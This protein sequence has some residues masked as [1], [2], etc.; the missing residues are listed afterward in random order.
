MRRFAFPLLALSLWPLQSQA[1]SQGRVDDNP[2]YRKG[3]AALADHLPDL[4]IGPLKKALEEF[5]GNTAATLAIRLRLAEAHIRAGRIET[6]RDGAEGQGSAALGYLSSLVENKNEEAIFWAAQAHILRAELTEAV[7][8]LARLDNAE[9]PGMRGRSALSRA[10]LLAL[11]GNPGSAG[12]LLDKLT[13]S[14]EAPLS[15]DARILHATILL[16]RDELVQAATLLSAGPDPLDRNRKL[17]LRFLRAKLLARTDKPEAIKVFQSIVEETDETPRLLRHS[18]EV[19]LA[20]CLQATGQSEQAIETLINLIDKEPR[21]SLL[22]AAFHRL[23]SWAVTESQKNRIEQQFSTWANLNNRDAPSEPARGE[24]ILSPDTAQRSGYAIYYYAISLGRQNSAASNEKARTLLNWLIENLPRHP[25]N[26]PATLEVAKLQIAAQQKQEAIA[27]L[28]GLKTSTSSNR[29]R[30]ET[31]RLLGRLEFEQKDFQAA[32]AAFLPIRQ[33]LTNPWEDISVINAGVSLL[34][35]GDNSEFAAL[36]RSIEDSKTQATL[37]L[38]RALYQSSQELNDARPDLDRFL[39]NYPEDPRIPEARLAM[40]E[41]HLRLEPS[42]EASHRQVL[43]ELRSLQNTSL[44][45][46]LDLRRLLIHLRL[47]GLTDEWEP[48]IA[49]SKLFLNA[50]K[51]ER[52]SSMVRLKVS[53]AYFKNGNLSEAQARFQEIVSSSDDEVIRE[54]ATYYAARA[55]LKLNTGSS[56]EEAVTLL[57]RVIDNEGPLA[58]EARL[59]LADSQIEEAPEKSIVLLRPLLSADSPA[60][61]DALMLTA[62]AHRE[63]GAPSDLRSALGIYDAVLARPELAYPLSNRLFWLKGQVFEELGQSQPAL[64]AYY[65]VVRRE[66]LPEAEHP[67]EWYYFSRCAF[68]AVEILEQGALPRW[69]AA[70]EILRKVENSESPWRKEAGRRRAEIQLEHQLFDS[71]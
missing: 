34:R 65:H 47:A 31:G 13:T 16:D 30:E 68:D 54:T 19:F 41:E 23:T 70:V 66:N 18:A 38:E 32:A 20:E 29:L 5:P 59:L 67:S 69:D 3:V 33:D 26:S 52:I 45:F 14:S 15:H 4:A 35:A 10:H 64:D 58:L 51:A 71:R 63:R 56:R 2:S 40:A 44:A 11:L 7:D 53:E 55:A 6:D 39:R 36:L 49:A 48:A 24:I 60:R 1:Q 22:E 25:A 28:N 9:D 17:H 46:P 21:T 62:D 42:R 27:T 50:H 37:I 8:L 57:Q 12:A 43:E 61:L